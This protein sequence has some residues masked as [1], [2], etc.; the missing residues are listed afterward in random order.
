MYYTSPFFSLNQNHLQNGER[1]VV[2]KALGRASQSAISVA[3][4]LKR[5]IAGLHQIN[6]IANLEIV[7]VYQPLEEGLEIVEKSRYVSALRIV[8]SLD[9]LDTNH[10]GYQAPIDP[11]L[12]QDE[13]SERAARAD[14]PRM[15][16]PRR[17]DGFGR[18][19]RGRGRGGRGRGRGGRGRGRGGRGGRPMMSS[20]APPAHMMPNM[21]QA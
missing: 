14:Q 7:D 17:R 21:T 2:L 16:R 19:G 1:F 13:E 4:V 6:E 11:S 8:L 15:I 5:R 18:G 20:M 10:V 3:E 9:E 12:V